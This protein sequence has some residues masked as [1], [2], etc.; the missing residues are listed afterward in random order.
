MKGIIFITLNSFV[1]D[2]FGFDAW[3]TLLDIA[4]PP[5]KGIYVATMTYQNEELTG[6]VET[7][8]KQKNLEVGD[9][10]EAFGIY[11][12][13]KLSEHYP[14]FIK[15]GMTLKDF[16][17]TIHNIIHVEVKKLYEDANLPRI[18][19]EDSEPMR[20][21]MIYRSPRKLCRLAEG[22]IKG[23]AEH[24]RT[25]ID[26]TQTICMHKGGDHCRIEMAFL[27]ALIPIK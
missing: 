1:V 25:K 24:F 15:P 5:S 14:V 16:L 26:V 2:K 8:C 13:E 27:S 10:I 17:L 22:L 20:L 3:E 23:A 6:L 9:A 12:F 11:M 4:Q 21:V 7:L 18:S 19:Y